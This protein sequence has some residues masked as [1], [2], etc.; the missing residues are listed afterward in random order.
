[1]IAEQKQQWRS[2]DNHMV[3]KGKVSDEIISLWIGIWAAQLA[4]SM[5]EQ[6]KESPVDLG[7][8]EIVATQEEEAEADAKKY[9]A[10]Q[11]L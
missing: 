6:V 9:S 4:C 11:S 2:S 8:M 5:L 10:S 3:L 7:A 1:M